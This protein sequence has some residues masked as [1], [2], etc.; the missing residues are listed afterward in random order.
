VVAREIVLD[1]VKFVELQ[2]EPE[3]ISLVDYDEQ[4]F[5]VL[6]RVGTRPLEVQELIQVQVTS[7]G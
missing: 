1:L 7:V 2:F 5:V 3:F 4:A 6:R